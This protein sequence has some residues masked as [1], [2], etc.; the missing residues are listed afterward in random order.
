MAWQ[1]DDSTADGS[2]KVFNNGG[3]RSRNTIDSRVQR[4]GRLT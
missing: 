4:K 1:V 3:Q 2:S